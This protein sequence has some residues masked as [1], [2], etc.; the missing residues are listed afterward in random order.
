MK[1]WSDPSCQAVG[2]SLQVE[3]PVSESITGIDLVEWQLRVAAGEPLPAQELPLLVR[4][5][6]TA[7]RLMAT[8]DRQAGR[9]T[10]L[11]MSQVR[12]YA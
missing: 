3:H 4:G 9:P 7:K 2:R 1:K 11:W 12:V 8:P 6:C 5:L 10:A